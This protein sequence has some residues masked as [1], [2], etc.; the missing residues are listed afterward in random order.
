MD[1][2]L[3]HMRAEG[4][5]KSQLLLPDGTPLIF[6]P[7]GR[8]TTLPPAEP[9]LLENPY[10]NISEY[11]TLATGGLASPY[12]RIGITGQTGSGGE[13]AIPHG[14]KLAT[15]ATLRHSSGH[16]GL[17]VATDENNYALPGE[18]STIQLA[19]IPARLALSKPASADT[20]PSLTINRL[21]A[22][23]KADF[24][25]VPLEERGGGLAAGGGIVG[26]SSATGT[27]QRRQRTLQH[28]V[29]TTGGNLTSI[30]TTTTTTQAGT[31]G[32][33]HT[34][35]GN[36]TGSPYYATGDIAGESVAAHT[37]QSQGTRQIRRQ[38]GGSG[39]VS[40]GNIWEG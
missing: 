39:R 16:P 14:A 1:E 28:P 35:P 26:S 9:L 2:T 17:Q 27:Q 32:K 4:N 38:A 6:T 36:L 37:L 3:P 24:A 21:H 5:I 34:G 20:K 31:L 10:Q 8:A 40:P 25:R 23:N 29:R 33:G 22:V 15:L 7:Q 13:L 11:R 19:G 12:E 30:G 18:A